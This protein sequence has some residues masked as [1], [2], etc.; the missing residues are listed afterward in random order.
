MVESNVTLSS[1]D[2]LASWNSSVTI[3]VGSQTVMIS[4]SELVAECLVVGEDYSCNCSK[5]YAWSNEVCYNY[6]CCTEA[7][8]TQNVSQATSICD[9]KTNENAKACKEEAFKNEFWPKTPAGVT[10]FNQSCPEGRV[11]FKSRTCNGTEIWQDVFS[12]CVSEELSKVTDAANNFLNGLGATQEVAKDIF[13]GIKNSSSL[14]SGTGDD[15]ADI[16]A[17]IG[18]IGVMASASQNIVLDEAVFP[19]LVDAASNMVN[20]NWSEVNDSVRHEMSSDYLSNV[21]SLVKNIHINTSEG[22]NSTNLELKFCSSDNCNISVFG[23]DVNMN[24]TNGTMKTMGVKNLMEKLRNNKFLGKNRSSIL[25][26]AT[27]IGS[28]DSD[29]KIKMFFPDEQPSTEERLCVFWDT[30]NKD[31]S[32]EG[33]VANAT[34]DNQTL[35]ECNHLTSFSVLMGKSPNKDSKHHNFIT[36]V[37]LGVSILSLLIF[38]F[39]ESLVWPAVTK[40][41]LSHFRH[42]AVVNIAV[43]RLLADCSFLASAFPE[44][45]SDNWCFILTICKHLFYL[46]MFCWMLCLSA[47]LVHQLIFVFSPVRKRV[48]M[49]LSSIVGYVVPITIVGISFVYYKYNDEEYYDKESCWLKYEGLLEGSIH[50]FVLPVYTIV[51]SNIFSMVVVIVTLVKTSVPDSSKADDKETAK[52]ILKVL[53][54]LAPVFGITWIIGFALLLID[55]DNSMYNVATYIFNILNSFQGLFILLTGCVGEQKVR[56]E[57]I[58]IVMVKTGRDTDCGDRKSSSDFRSAPRDP[59]E[60]TS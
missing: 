37:G 44:L 55:E 25:L 8:C 54:F 26:S 17:S 40:T 38:L 12:K 50:A 30:K 32:G 53:V 29:I 41:N 28:N 51:L 27:L 46:A 31:W 52:S 23:V 1:D 36:Y 60:N 39:V 56:Q 6:G 15:I 47:M 35:C 7:T 43:F 18:I 9:P 59:G 4:S 42:T 33:C 3:S 11:G 34:D 20:S 45:L 24:K 58:R 48:F 2:I 49:Y 22:F 57:V 5:G 21:E 14:S 16:S 19:D 13:E 10:V